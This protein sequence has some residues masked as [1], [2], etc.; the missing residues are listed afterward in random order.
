[1]QANS[2]SLWMTQ[3]WR[4]DRYKSWQLRLLANW[5]ICRKTCWRIGKP[6]TIST[7]C[8]RKKSLWRRWPGLTRKSALVRLTK[9]SICRTETSCRTMSKRRTSENQIHL[10][11][12]LALI[13]KSWSIQPFFGKYTRSKRNS[14]IAPS[15]SLKAF[16]LCSVGAT[17]LTWAHCSR[18][19]MWILTGE[20]NHSDT[21]WTK[22]II[23]LRITR[24]LKKSIKISSKVSKKYSD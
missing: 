20:R 21:K 14:S 10:V 1:M 4:Q 19:S 16:L 8:H 22:S 11:S 7:T 13:G 24:D 12:A 9:T 15:I 2:C 6:G 18:C 23:S 17:S 5:T 3:L